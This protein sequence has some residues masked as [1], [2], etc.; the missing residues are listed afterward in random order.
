[1]DVVTLTT[2]CSTYISEGFGAHDTVRRSQTP[3]FEPLLNGLESGVE[4]FPI[5]M[6]RSVPAKRNPN[7]WW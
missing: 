1:M 6:M 3:S 7:P 4:I 2:D 5:S